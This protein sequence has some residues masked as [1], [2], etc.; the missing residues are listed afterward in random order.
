VPIRRP[1]TELLLDDA[2]RR[3]RAGS[4]FATLEFT[5]V[6]GVHL[7]SRAALP[8]AIDSKGTRP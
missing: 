3:N 6:T 4:K 8:F 5:S 2:G 7:S 1:V